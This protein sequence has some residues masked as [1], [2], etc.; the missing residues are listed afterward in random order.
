MN[1]E[2]R[3]VLER[4]AKLLRAYRV[5]PGSGNSYMDGWRHGRVEQTAQDAY[6]AVITVLNYEGQFSRPQAQRDAGSDA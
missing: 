1:D 6:L 4:A 3:T 5:E 2:E